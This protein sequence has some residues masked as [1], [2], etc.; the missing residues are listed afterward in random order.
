MVG[1]CF[2]SFFASNVLCLFARVC[3]GAKSF[4]AASAYIG[5]VA[6]WSVAGG[7]SA[8][9]V[10]V[11]HAHLSAVRGIALEPLKRQYMTTCGQDR[12]VNNNNNNHD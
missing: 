3:C 4:I 12:Y 1:A 5:C 6:V 11:F 2:T 9:L 7:N 10:H 8:S